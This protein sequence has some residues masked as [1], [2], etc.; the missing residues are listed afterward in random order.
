[1]ACLYS[2]IFHDLQIPMRSMNSK[3]WLRV[4]YSHVFKWL[5]WN[6]WSRRHRSETADLRC[7]GVY[8]AGAWNQLLE[9][10]PKYPLQAKMWINPRAVWHH[11]L[12]LDNPWY[13]KASF[14]IVHH[15]TTLCHYH[16]NFRLLYFI[17]IRRNWQCSLSVS[18]MYY[19]QT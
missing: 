3:L 10:N 9:K 7:V 6:F 2:Y 1:M 17:S 8:P 5:L 16:L 13:K 14:L 11:E 18:L 4:I 12:V 19:I 15:A